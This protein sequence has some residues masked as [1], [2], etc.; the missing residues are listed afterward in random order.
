MS[1]KRECCWTLPHRVNR[2]ST[3]RGLRGM[4]HQAPPGA[5]ISR[6]LMLSDLR[7]KTNT[8]E[9]IPDWAG[10]RPRQEVSLFSPRPA[11]GGHSTTGR[12]PGSEFPSRRATPTTPRS[13]D[14]RSRS[15][16][17]ATGSN[18]WPSPGAGLTNPTVPLIPSCP[19]QSS[20]RPGLVQRQPSSDSGPFVDGSSTL[21]AVQT[22]VRSSHLVCRPPFRSAEPDY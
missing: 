21:V 9:R 3:V 1:G 7:P 12:K 17:S 13:V 22:P 11:H 10:S 19:S 8:D 20:L 16:R 14:D 2:G 18:G 4:N 6:R 5:L 15:A